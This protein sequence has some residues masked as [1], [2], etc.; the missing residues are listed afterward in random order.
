VRDGFLPEDDR[1][2]FRLRFPVEFLATAAAT[3]GFEAEFAWT[4]YREAVARG[5]G[6]GSNRP[7][8][9]ASRSLRAGGASAERPGQGPVDGSGGVRA[10]SRDDDLAAARLWAAFF[11]QP[12][13]R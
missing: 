3:L 2:L 11:P 10:Q 12:S 1:N 8:F 4:G 9:S 7:P 13:A 6:G 5:M